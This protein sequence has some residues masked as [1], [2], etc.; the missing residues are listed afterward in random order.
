M[1]KPLY[2]IISNG[3]D[4]SYY[5]TYTFSTKLIELLTRLHDEDKIDYE[6]G[7]SDGDGFHYSTIMVPDECTAASMNIGVVG[8]EL[9]Q[10]YSKTYDTVEDAS[11]D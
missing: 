9:F 1:S 6:T 10:Y 2:V 4:G 11:D 3:G 8:D 5:P 7:Y